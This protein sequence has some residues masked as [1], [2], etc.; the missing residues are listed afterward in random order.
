MQ[1]SFAK[2]SIFLTLLT[3]KNFDIFFQDF[4]NSIVIGSITKE[5]LYKTGSIEL[6]ENKT[7]NRNMARFESFIYKNNFL[8]PFS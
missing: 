2:L 5:F 6:E 4:F 8:I 1:N 3:I 7:R